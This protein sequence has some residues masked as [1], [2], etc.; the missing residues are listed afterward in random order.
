M[1]RNNTVHLVASGDIRP[2]RFV[3]ISGANA[4][5]EADANEETI[6]IS[7][8]STKGPPGISGSSTNHAESTDPIEL[9]G[10]GDECKVE[11][12]GSFSAGDKLKSDADGK[13]VVSATTGA[14][15]QNVSA[16]ALE[17]STGSGQLVRVVVER[18]T[19]YPAL[20]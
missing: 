1:A 14:T 19:Y 5:A 16:R 15:M 7:G 20:A 12:G 2:C 3:K 18:D 8:D 13:A 10:L 9:Y 6:G 4:G 17:A 11:A